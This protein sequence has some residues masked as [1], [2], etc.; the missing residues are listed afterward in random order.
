MDLTDF[1]VPG[2]SKWTSQIL[3]MPIW[4]PVRDPRDI[5]SVDPSY[6]VNTSVALGVAQG[7]AFGD[8]EWIAAG[9]PLGIELA[10]FIQ[11]TLLWEDF[12][13]PPVLM[14]HFGTLD[15]LVFCALGLKQDKDAG[16]Q[17]KEAME[18]FFSQLNGT[19]ETGG[20]WSISQTLIGCESYKLC[21]NAGVRKEGQEF[22]IGVVKVEFY[23]VIGVCYPWGEVS[24]TMESGGRVP[25]G[26]SG[27][28][29]VVGKGVERLTLPYSPSC[30]N[31][32]R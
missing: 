19:S 3:E 12:S 18:S 15:D 11:A 32:L 7:E 30:R 20:S 23:E 29:E 24:S 31:R 17:V 5:D 6:V 10:A 1:T 4:L 8:K 16:S 2:Y 26:Q 9:T 13:L 25:W 14:D 22:V 27:E 21:R 28:I